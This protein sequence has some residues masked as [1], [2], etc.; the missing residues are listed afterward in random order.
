MNNNNQ[1]TPNLWWAFDSSEN[2]FTTLPT[3]P[4]FLP[5]LIIFGLVSLFRSSKNNQPAFVQA[6]GPLVKSPYWIKQYNRYHE[7]LEKEI[8]G[9][10]DHGR[11][12]SYAEQYE[13]KQIEEY[14]RN[15]HGW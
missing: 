10:I 11:D 7:L 14:L 4:F 6:A 8:R 1:P 12:L 2:T 15:P 13:F 9:K 3:G 5:A